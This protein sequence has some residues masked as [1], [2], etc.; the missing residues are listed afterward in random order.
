V[1]SLEDGLTRSSHVLTELTHNVGIAAAVVA[2]QQVLDRVELL[3]LADRRVLAV[4]VT[5]NHTVHNRVVTLDEEIPPDELGS[6]RNYLNLHFT[7]WTLAAAREEL[8][9]R[10]RLQ[11]AYY[12]ALLKRL[13]MLYARGFLNIAPD[14]EVHLEGT[15]YLF[16]EDLHMTRESMG[17]LLRA[18]EE[19]RRILQL[20][21]RF[22]EGR[23]GAVS[24]HVGLGDLHPAMKDLSLI[25]V[26]VG[27]GGRATAKL[28]VLGP[29]RMHYERVMS[30]VAHVGRALSQLDA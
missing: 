21:D 7:G 5:A 20:L 30:A 8:D 16:G 13:N 25:G 15:S 22:L 27:A 4:I 12:D 11:S 26:T 10:L 18:L 23:E 17:E 9:R 28:A 3:P 1:E 6:I 14:P 19:K 29:M 2:A 24:V